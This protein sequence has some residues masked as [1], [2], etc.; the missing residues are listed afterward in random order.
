MRLSPPS[1]SGLVIV[2]QQTGLERYQ[3]IV[4]G[5]VAHK[6]PGAGFDL[7]QSVIHGDT[8]LTV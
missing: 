8:A 7:P 2:T 1:P 6:I 3:V 5:K 4:P